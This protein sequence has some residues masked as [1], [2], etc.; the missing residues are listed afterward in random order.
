ME[1]LKFRVFVAQIF[2]IFVLGAVA[3]A[4]GSLGA[5]SSWGAVTLAASP[6]YGSDRSLVAVIAAVSVVGF[7]ISVLSVWGMIAVFRSWKASY[8]D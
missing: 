6:S 3:L 2:G 8:S 4:F 5:C 7:A 1:G